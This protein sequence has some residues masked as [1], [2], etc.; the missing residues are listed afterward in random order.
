MSFSLPTSPNV[1]TT[2]LSSCL[3]I[4]HTALAGTHTNIVIE[5]LA[6]R[7]CFLRMRLKPVDLDLDFEEFR[8]LLHHCSGFEINITVC[9]VTKKLDI[10]ALLCKAFKNNIVYNKNV[11]NTTPSLYCMKSFSQNLSVFFL[12][13]CFAVRFKHRGRSVVYSSMCDIFKLAF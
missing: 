13:C 7:L 11:C 9:T 10:R 12:D 5:E 1:F 3:V 4:P 6:L 8:G 2:K